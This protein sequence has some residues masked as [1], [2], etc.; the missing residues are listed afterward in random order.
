MDLE[1]FFSGFTSKQL[2]NAQKAGEIDESMTPEERMEDYINFMNEPIDEDELT[3]A[4][5]EFGP[6]AYKL[7]L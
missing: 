5:A 7:K 2:V 3:W 6:N 1:K 4:M